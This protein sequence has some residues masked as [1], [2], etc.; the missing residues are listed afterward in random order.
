MTSDGTEERMEHGTYKSMPERRSALIAGWKQ[1]AIDLENYQ[2]QEVIPAAVAAPQEQLPAV[3]VQVQGSIAVIDNLAVFGD[4]LRAYVERIN[5]QP[6]TDDDFA[7]LEA[8]VKSL[9]AAE[10]ALTAAEN[11]AMGQ[12]ASLDTLRR[13][14]ADYRA[15]ARSNRLIV[16]K[17]VSAEKEN[18]R[19]AIIQ[20]GKTRLQEHVAALEAR[21]G[22]PYIPAITSA[23]FA[24]VCK[25]LKTMSSI[26]N[27]VDTSWQQTD[28]SR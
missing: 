4:A 16:E 11:N 23:D 22:K 5:K 2:H 12:T 26:Q 17:L 21:I 13:T 3:S 6:Q 15:L 19:N 1:F 28:T 14:V 20:S 8:T 25:G 10:D 9:K 18:R 24:G 7:T 27:A